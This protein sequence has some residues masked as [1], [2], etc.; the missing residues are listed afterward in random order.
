MKYLIRKMNTVWRTLSCTALTVA[1]LSGCRE[2]LREA[3]GQA[4]L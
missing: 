2:P 3:R 1:V 4:A